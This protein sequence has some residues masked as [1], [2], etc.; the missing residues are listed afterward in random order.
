MLHK[1]TPYSWL[2]LELGSE[3]HAEAGLAACCAARSW[4][5][6]YIYI[7]N[8]PYV[9]AERRR[10]CSSRRRGEGNLG[11]SAGSQLVAVDFFWEM[12][13]GA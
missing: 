1:N 13:L 2:L 9:S 6:V 5:D 4:G 11:F 7:Y 8:K 10:A 3:R 12:L